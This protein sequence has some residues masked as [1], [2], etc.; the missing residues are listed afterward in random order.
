MRAERTDRVIRVNR[1]AR[2]ANRNNEVEAGYVDG[3]GDHPDNDMDSDEQIA[4]F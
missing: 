1:E 3:E 4:T 2:A